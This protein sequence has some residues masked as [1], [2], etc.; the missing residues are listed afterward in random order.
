[1]NSAEDEDSEDGAKYQEMIV[2]T[3]NRYAVELSPRSQQISD[4]GPVLRNLAALIG[5]LSHLSN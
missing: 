3:E 5:I 4:P 1:M 2:G